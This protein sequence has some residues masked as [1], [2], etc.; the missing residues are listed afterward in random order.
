MKLTHIQRHDQSGRHVPFSLSRPQWASG[1][2]KSSPSL[3][4]DGNG[5][6]WWG[7]HGNYSCSL[8]QLL[9]GLSYGGRLGFFN[10]NPFSSPNTTHKWQWLS[11]D[12]TS[13]HNVGFT[14]SPVSHKELELRS[15]HITI[16]KRMKQ[17]SNVWFQMLQKTF[18]AVKSMWCAK[19]FPSNLGQVKHFGKY[20]Q[21]IPRDRWDNWYTS[22]RS[23][24]YK[25]SWI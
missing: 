19:M 9:T 18:S 15:P 22:C 3:L 24:Q 8:H 7:G 23:V 20:I 1:L 13:P 11:M 12:S 4:L 17:I 10:G 25:W 2:C 6:K 16:S 14:W 5:E 21:L